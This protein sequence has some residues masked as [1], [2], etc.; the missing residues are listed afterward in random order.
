MNKIKRFDI[1]GR[2]EFHEEGNLYDA[3]D[4]DE[5][6]TEAIKGKTKEDII[7]NISEIFGLDN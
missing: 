6:V 2:K 3:D 5:A 1:Y 4:V 7:L